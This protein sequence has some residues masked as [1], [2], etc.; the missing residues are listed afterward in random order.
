MPDLFNGG[1][2]GATQT[3]V[4]GTRFTRGKVIASDHSLIEEVVPGS[5]DSQAVFFA[6][7]RVQAKQLKWI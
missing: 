6:R 5:T 3:D 7:G 2:D 1:L 4:P